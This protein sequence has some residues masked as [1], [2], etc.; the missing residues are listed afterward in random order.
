MISE[1]QRSAVQSFTLKVV[2]PRTD[3]RAKALQRVA[4]VSHGQVVGKAQ[5]S[6]TRHDGFLGNAGCGKAYDDAHAGYDR[7]AAAK[8]TTAISA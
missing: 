6:A 1:A 8:A 4:Q 3:R 2:G 7:S 5:R